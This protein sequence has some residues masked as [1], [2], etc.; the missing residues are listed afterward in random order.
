M[1]FNIKFFRLSAGVSNYGCRA[2][3]A[4]AACGVI[5][6]CS[7]G[8]Q[9][10]GDTRARVWCCCN[11][12]QS[13]V[14]VPETWGRQRGRSSSPRCLIPKLPGARARRWPDLPDHVLQNG[15][16]RA[17]VPAAPSLHIS[18]R[19]LCS[20][21]EGLDPTLS[22]LDITIL[23]VSSSGVSIKQL[24]GILKCKNASHK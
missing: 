16:T 11:G 5:S 7:V 4:K 19:G 14:P 12:G 9:P 10:E 2:I 1:H 22:H 21:A 3:S 13:M 23:W 17:G 24:C 8:V 6:I 20:P 18:N 15:G